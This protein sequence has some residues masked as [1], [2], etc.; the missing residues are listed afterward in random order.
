MLNRCRYRLLTWITV[1]ANAST[2][3]YV[4]VKV[5]AGDLVDIWLSIVL[6][7]RRCVVILVAGTTGLSHIVLLKI[8]RTEK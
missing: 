5:I 4:Y 8:M 2:G 1:P 7:F 3:F 6:N